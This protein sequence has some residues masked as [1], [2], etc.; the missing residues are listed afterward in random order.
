[1]HP[2]EGEKHPLGCT[3]TFKHVHFATLDSHPTSCK[4]QRSKKNKSVDHVLQDKHQKETP[5]ASSMS[6]RIWSKPVLETIQKSDHL[7]GILTSLWFSWY[8]SKTR[9]MRSRGRLEHRHADTK[10]R[11]R[12]RVRQVKETTLTWRSPS[13]QST[14]KIAGTCKILKMDTQK[15]PQKYALATSEEVEMGSRKRHFPKV[16]ICSRTFPKGA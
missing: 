16:T 1:M 9:K 6:F 10:I 15:D 4:H 3:K 13:S 5:K 2:N 12:K 11:K 7:W 14:T 8:S